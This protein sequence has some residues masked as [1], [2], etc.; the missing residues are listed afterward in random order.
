MRLWN[1]ST[2]KSKRGFLKRIF[3][4]WKGTSDDTH[5]IQEDHIEEEIQLLHE[6]LSGLGISED[7]MLEMRDVF[8]LF[9]KVCQDS[10]PPLSFYLTSHFRTEVAT[11]APKSWPLCSELM[12]VTPRRE[13]SSRS[14]LRWTST[15]TARSTCLSSS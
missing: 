6:H 1:V 13:R 8:Q 2:T 14:W 7:F 11:F 12:A 15:T 4:K 10:F 5:V 3:S 9:D